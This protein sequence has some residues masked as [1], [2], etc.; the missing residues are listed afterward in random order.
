MVDLSVKEHLV[1]GP[2]P[3]PGEIQLSTLQPTIN[4][5]IT[6][7]NG[8]TWLLRMLMILKVTGISF[9]SATVLNNKRLL[10]ISTSPDQRTPRHLNGN[11]LCIIH[12]HWDLNSI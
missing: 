8:K 4:V 12:H 3:S 7:M 5:L 1:Y 11:K 10:L 2:F 6:E 9:I